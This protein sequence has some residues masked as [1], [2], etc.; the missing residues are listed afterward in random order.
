MWPCVCICVRLTGH[1]AIPHMVIWWRAPASKSFPCEYVWSPMMLWSSTS[2]GLTQN[3]GQTQGS[4]S[5]GT[6]TTKSQS[7]LESHLTSEWRGQ[8]ILGWLL[9]FWIVVF[10]VCVLFSGGKKKAEWIC[11]TLVIYSREWGETTFQSLSL[12]SKMGLEISSLTEPK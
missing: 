6:D 4:L 1:S 9:Y 3:A 10:C 8:W 11:W 5:L 7:N 12:I 2:A